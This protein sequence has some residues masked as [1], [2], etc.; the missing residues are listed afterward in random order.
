MFKRIKSMIKVEKEAMLRFLLALVGLVAAFGTAIL[1]TVERL[2][3]NAI[4]SAVLASL[5]LLIAGAVGLLTVPYLARRVAIARVRDAF[6]YDVTREGLIYLG[7]TLIIGIAAL[8]TGNNLLF[9]IVSVMLAA[10][11]VSGTASAGVLRG[12]ELDISLPAQAFAKTTVAGR[13]KLHNQRRFM[14]AF[15][16]SVVPPKAAKPHR[17]LHY[18]KTTFSF[19][20]RKPSV[21]LPDISLTFGPE[22]HDPSPPVLQECVYF[23]YIPAQTT[24]SAAVDISFPRRGRYAQE[25]F[26]VSTKFPFS[27]LAKTRRMP[28]SRE[29]IVYPSV[30]ATDELLDV[31]PTIRG[32]FESF[33]RG[34]GYDLYRIRNHVP[35]DSARH[36]DWKATA[37]TGELKVREFT[38][39]DERKLR[40]VFDNPAPG[41]ISDQEY[42][43]AVEIAASLA[44]H[45]ESD[46][47]E[48]SFAAPEY[49]GSNDVHEFLRYLALVQPKLGPSILDS[50]PAANDYSLI[51]TARPRGSVPTSLWTSSYIIFVDGSKRS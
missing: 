31:L 22:P 11:I 16:I 34:R 7:S 42:E 36:V 32:E 5:S 50:L 51:I 13:V 49:S 15:S 20:A 21:V 28:V 35:E 18:E 19:P 40:V 29:L 41:V 4:T 10:V 24:V 45:F 25:S 12:L 14:P 9:I 23:P 44:W 2:A 43:R 17:R 3:G 46:A 26:G 27:F 33:V 47:T 38:R 39:E 1:S 6:D 8:N 48:L 37:K 30:E